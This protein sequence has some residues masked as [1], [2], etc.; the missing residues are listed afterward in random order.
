M[1]A[2]NVRISLPEQVSG[3]IGTLRGAGYEAWA[4]GGCVRD[5]LLGRTPDDW[6][7]TTSARPEQVKK[8]FPRTVDTGI[9][10]GTVTVLAGRTGFEVTTYR[11][12]GEYE[13]GRH[14]KEV[15]FTAS[16]EED[17][18]RRDFTINAMAYSEEAGLI[19]LFGGR[20]DMAR[21]LIRCVG[22]PEERFSED[23]LRLMRAVRFSAQLGYALEPETRRAV[24]AMAP[25]LCRISA[26]RIQ[27]EL[28]KLLCSAYPERIRVCWE[29]GLTAA[30]FP[31]FD[32]M[33]ETPQNNPHHCYTVGEHTVHAL[34]AA[35]PDRALRLAVLFHDIGKPQT[36]SA[37]SAGVDHFYGHAEAGA[38]I[39]GDV[40]RR[41]KFDNETREL[42]IRLVRAHDVKIEPGPKYMR[43]AMHRLGT[44]LF[45]MLFDLKEADLR[46]QSAYKREEK[47][48]QLA[49][50]RRDYAAVLEAGDCVSLRDLAVNGG[51]LTAAGLRPGPEMGRLL[52]K[53]LELV[54][55]EPSRNTREFLLE[56]VKKAVEASAS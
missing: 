3:I 56:E 23:A 22:D 2:E 19:D 28:V 18:K 33:M 30:F 48:E 47:W 5:S 36:K 21:G 41:L 50:M 7:I 43:R 42:V 53:L 12:D 52:Q 37:D 10:H 31:E 39:A 51:D 44:D 26:E 38:R 15:A 4:V 1:T 35:P 9:R 8:L 27:T 14:P 13:D 40:L 11:V 45:P 17:L 6:D 54:L 49:A 46:A 24:C 16:L 29:T 34:E 20:E 32:R 25:S 55:E